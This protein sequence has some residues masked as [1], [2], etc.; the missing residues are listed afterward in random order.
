MVLFLLFDR[1]EDRVPHLVVDRFRKM[2]PA[3]YVFDKN[4]LTGADDAGFAVA[5]GQLHA[6]IEVDDVLAARGRMPGAVMLRLGLAKDDA[7]CG[8]AG[9]G[10]AFR[11]FL[12]PVDLYVAPVGFTVRV[13]VE[14]VYS[15]AHGRYVLCFFRIAR[16][17]AH[18]ASARIACRGSG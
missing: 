4:D 11:S 17:M 2:A 12:R 7:G 15:D 3:G 16:R 13:T 14:V 18:Y 10:L 8:Q 1:H 5:G 9:G 6:G